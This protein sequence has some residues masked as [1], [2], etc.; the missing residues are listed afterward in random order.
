M[1]APH[2]IQIHAPHVLSHRG[3]RR[4]ARTRNHEHTRARTHEGGKSR[5]RAHTHFART[6]LQPKAVGLPL[7][8]LGYIFLSG[9]VKMSFPLV[10]EGRGGDL[11]ERRRKSV[12]RSSS[13]REYRLLSLFGLNLKIFCR[14]FALWGEVGWGGEHV[15][16]STCHP[17]SRAPHV[18]S[19]RGARRQPRTRNHAHTR[20]R[21]HEGG[22]SRA[23]AHTHFART[24]LQPKAVGP[25]LVSLGFI[26][27]E[28]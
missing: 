8:S 18:L 12:L 6:N 13:S 10:W 24:H 16:R 11:A 15:V 19:H 23:R 4:Q 7:G 3:A 25:P 5:A 21:T 17:N 20:A 1:F 26:F 27:W 2:V 9:L 22:K 14:S 28:G